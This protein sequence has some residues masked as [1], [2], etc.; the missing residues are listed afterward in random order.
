MSFVGGLFGGSNPSLTS[1]IGQ[2]SSLA[3]FLNTTG[4]SDVAASSNFE[5][6]LLSGDWSKI[7]TLLAPQISAIQRRS[8]Q[9]KQ[10]L[11]QFGGRSGGTTAAIYKSGDDV[12]AAVND[13][14][15]GLT[16]SAATSLG[17]EGAGLIGEG[18]TAL[19]MNAKFS[20]QQLDNWRSSIVGKG[21]S[22]AVQGAEAFG[23]GAAGGALPGGP[24]AAAGGQ[25]ALA[26]FLNGY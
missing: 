16:G 5:K 24:G 7:N 4:T 17:S 8:Q 13:M 10:Q 18:E 3:S 12:N 23:M 9:Q 2:S 14:V 19:D 20:Q 15:S 26:S 21:I 11:G 6:G 25:S 1:D 22:T